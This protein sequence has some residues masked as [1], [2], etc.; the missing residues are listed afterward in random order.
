MEWQIY[1][2]DACGYD[3]KNSISS[4]YAFDLYAR[5]ARYIGNQ[6]YAD[7]AVTAYDCTKKAGLVTHIY[8]V[9]DVTDNR[10]NCG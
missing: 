10:T 2:E 1:L 3:Y 9:V 4:G 8:D 6:I 5:L 7:L